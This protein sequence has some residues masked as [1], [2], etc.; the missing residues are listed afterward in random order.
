MNDDAKYE[1]ASKRTY[2]D[3]AIKFIKSLNR[4][5]LITNENEANKRYE[6]ELKNLETRILFRCNKAQVRPVQLLVQ[7]KN[8]LDKAWEDTITPIFQ[9]ELLRIKNEFEAIKLSRSESSISSLEELQLKLST[10]KDELVAAVRFSKKISDHRFNIISN[11]IS[12]EY[13]KLTTMRFLKIRKFQE[14]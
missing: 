3:A 4:A 8:I 11:I 9:Q 7:R 14:N 13:L 12:S 2:V 10:K 5:D 6:R 1:S